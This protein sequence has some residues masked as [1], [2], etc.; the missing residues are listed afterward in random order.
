M[1][2]VAR[3]VYDAHGQLGLKCGP[4]STAISD[5]HM[6]WMISLSSIP[7]GSPHA[8]SPGAVSRAPRQIFGEQAQPLIA[9]G[10]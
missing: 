2:T 5:L 9:R 7:Q 4:V 10:V 8:V 6:D 1:V 3:T